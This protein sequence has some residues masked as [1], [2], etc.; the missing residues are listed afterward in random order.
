M[1][2]GSD[3]RYVYQDIVLLSLCRLIRRGFTG[4]PTESLTAF[5]KWHLLAN[6]PQLLVGLPFPHPNFFW[7]NQNPEK[8]IAHQL[9]FASLA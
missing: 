9:G 7:D 2:G 6:L 5:R 8:F 1:H 3:R 4:Y